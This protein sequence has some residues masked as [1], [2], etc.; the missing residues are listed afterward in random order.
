MPFLVTTAIQSHEVI[1]TLTGTVGV[2]YKI[3]LRVRG[4]VDLKSYTGGSLVQ[5]YVL[6]GGTPVVDNNTVVS[7]IINSPA[8][9]YFLNVSP[10]LVVPT[11]NV[12]LDYTLDV[13]ARGDATLTLKVDNKN[14]AQY[15]GDVDGSLIDHDPV[16][17]Y[18]GI[19]LRVDTEPSEPLVEYTV[20]TGGG[21]RGWLWSAF[22]ENVYGIKADK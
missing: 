14:F 5:K 10:E 20:M 22:A 6:S 1:V 7:L 8:A 3:G 17:V 19:W 21:I 9:T 11:H 18:D 2:T 16:G 4:V 12:P 13:L 15:R